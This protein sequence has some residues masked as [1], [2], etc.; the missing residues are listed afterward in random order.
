M[1]EP[2]ERALRCAAPAALRT[3]ELDP[4]SMGPKVEAAC[5]FAEQ[6]GG[7]AAIGSLENAR[8]VLLGQAGTR[9]RAGDVETRYWTPDAPPSCPLS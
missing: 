5:S 4:G 6:S 2:R 1:P 3:L 8:H 9:V 7:T